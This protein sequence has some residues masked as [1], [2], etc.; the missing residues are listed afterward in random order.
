MEGKEQKGKEEEPFFLEPS[1]KIFQL[2]KDQKR[3][4]GKISEWEKYSK[5]RNII[6]GGPIE[7]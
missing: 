7:F 2:N 6:L 4:I 5:E 1:E 3:E